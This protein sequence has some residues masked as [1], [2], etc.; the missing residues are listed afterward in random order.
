MCVLVVCVCVCVMCVSVRVC[1][2]RSNHLGARMANTTV[3]Q[4]RLFCVELKNDCQVV[5]S[6]FFVVPKLTPVGMSRGP[7][8]GQDRGVRIRFSEVAA[9]KDLTYGDRHTNTAAF[10]AARR[11]CVW[12]LKTCV[13][14]T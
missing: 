8:Q 9:W 12:V 2:W 6:I 13:I 4:P 3:T 14:V 11:A 7:P 5:C 1:L 10:T